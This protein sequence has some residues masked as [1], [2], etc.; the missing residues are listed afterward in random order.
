MRA[1]V[2]I[3]VFLAGCS[4]GST[5]SQPPSNGAEQSVAATG[6]QACNVLTPQAAEK[7]L[8]RKVEKLSNDGGA[9]GLDICQYS[10]QGE[11]L[12]DT[13]NVSVTFYPLDLASFKSQAEAQGYKFEAIP[14]IGDAAYYSPDVGLYVGRGNRTAIYLLGAGG[15]DDA[16]DRV[17]ALAKETASRI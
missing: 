13:G 10:Y 14:G 11:R 9:A 12:M 17:I 4:G 6:S 2:L 7:A 15:M 5:E 16:R 1:A 8:G 3:S